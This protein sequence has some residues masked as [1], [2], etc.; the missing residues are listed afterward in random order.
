M[1]IEQQSAHPALTHTLR[2]VFERSVLGLVIRLRRRGLIG[3]GVR[4]I[5]I[6]VLS[7]ETGD[8]QKRLGIQS[9]AECTA[10][11]FRKFSSVAVSFCGELLHADATP[12]R[13][14]RDRLAA[15]VRCRENNRQHPRPDRQQLRWS[16]LLLRGEE[17]ME[18]NPDRDQ[19]DLRQGPRSKIAHLMHQERKH[20][21]K[22]CRLSINQISAAPVA[23]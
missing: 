23:R 9:I 1:N 4:P 11:R 15:A 6:D 2:S 16:L 7:L 20:K 5:G 3:R 8:N 17:S 18:K 22:P 19:T 12:D 21:I 10:N 14:S 13:Y